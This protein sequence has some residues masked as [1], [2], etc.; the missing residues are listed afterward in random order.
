MKKVRATT[1][2]IAHAL[3]DTCH[4]QTWRALK[5]TSYIKRYE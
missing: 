4:S 1:T 5:A 3:R 2:A